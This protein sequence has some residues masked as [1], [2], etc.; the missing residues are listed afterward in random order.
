[1]VEVPNSHQDF[2]YEKKFFTS[3]EFLNE[4][5]LFLKTSPVGFQEIFSSRKVNSLYLDN[6]NHDSYLD[7]ISGISSRL[8]LRLR[9]YGNSTTV[10]HPTLEVKKKEG[11][12]GSKYFYKVG[13]F[14]ISKPLSR[15]YLR[16]ILSDRDFNLNSPEL[17]SFL[18]PKLYC[19]YVRRY[20][21]S[22]KN[23][24]RITVDHKISYSMPYVGKAI[25][26]SKLIQDPSTVLEVKYSSKKDTS[27][28]KELFNFP[29]YNTR[30]SK[31]T[32]GIDQLI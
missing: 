30:F 20:F 14:D 5:Y 12:V 3:S 18:M 21:L 13:A 28:I 19:S 31:F 23:K 22:N 16:T 29:I 9:W 25:I 6:V 11:S 10:N 24:L 4:I 26:N 7:S 15:N 8:K 27:E 2:R 32:N 1:M 17:Q